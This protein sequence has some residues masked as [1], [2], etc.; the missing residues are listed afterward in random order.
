LGIFLGAV[1]AGIIGAIV[2]NMLQKQIDKAK[3]SDIV[4]EQ[5][6]KGNEILNLQHQV[7]TVNEAKLEEEKARAATTIK[8]R[9]SEAAATMK[10]SLEQIA[11]NCKENDSIAETQADIDRLFDELEDI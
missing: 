3:K 8:E 9:H 1:V 11:E 4:A 2:I 10:N 7:R 6:D 5:I